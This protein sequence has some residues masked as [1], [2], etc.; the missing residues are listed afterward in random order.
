M[1]SAAAAVAACRTM[2]ETN[3][4]LPLTPD[5]TLLLLLL[6]PMNAE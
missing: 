2:D 1:T 6:P 5:P 4:M 3:L